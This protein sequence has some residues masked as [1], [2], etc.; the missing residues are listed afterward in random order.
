MGR[1][2]EAKTW[3][4]FVSEVKYRFRHLKG[5]SQYIVV[6]TLCPEVVCTAIYPLVSEDRKCFDMVLIS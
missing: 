4:E 6:Q 1:L 5:Q 2:S 3:F